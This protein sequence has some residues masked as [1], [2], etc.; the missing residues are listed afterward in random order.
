MYT[1]RSAFKR[2]LILHGEDF[3]A[4]GYI[5]IP[6]WFRW[7]IRKNKEWAYKVTDYDVDVYCNHREYS[8]ED[9]RKFRGEYSFSISDKELKNL[10]RP[11]WI[12]G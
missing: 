2:W 3:R 1:M 12:K 9:R 7:Y 8:Y 4:H 5:R 6:S 11:E 10:H